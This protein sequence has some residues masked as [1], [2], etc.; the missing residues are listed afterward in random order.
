MRW[1][2]WLS[3]ICLFTLGLAARDRA[4]AAEPLL[5]AHA[6]NDYWHDR[7]LLDALDQG[8]ASVEADVFLVN[9]K[10]LVGHARDE[11]KADS[12]LESLY[13]TPLARRVQANGK[14]VFPLATRFFL[15][16][17]IK[18]D[19]DPTIAVLSKI[20]LGYRS[21]MTYVEDGVVHPGAITVVVSGNRPKIDAA[22]RAPRFF[23]VDGRLSDLDSQAPARVMPMISDNWS[24]HFSW[25]GSGPMPGDE[26]TKLREIVRKV[27]AKG[28]VV[29]FWET[30]ENEACW[31][32]LRAAEVDLIG[33]DQLER[34]ATFLRTAE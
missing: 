4:V 26:R 5:K 31:Q 3:L 24:N 14:S 16:V 10:L 29:R 2:A 6:H 20:L 17:D 23:G 19:A 28:R 15:L 11:L 27:Q 7:P 9:G 32:E 1:A 12:T 18:T 30:P 25:K 22:D 8:F 34:L 13:L 33:T 21:M